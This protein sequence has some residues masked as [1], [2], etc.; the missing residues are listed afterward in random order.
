MTCDMR[1][2]KGVMRLIARVCHDEK[3]VSDK[4]LNLLTAYIM[5]HW[6]TAR[7]MVKERKMCG[8]MCGGK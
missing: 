2:G 8:A 3:I 6:W 1:T 5:L 4:Q 7:I